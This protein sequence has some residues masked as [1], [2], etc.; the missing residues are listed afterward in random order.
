MP[1]SDYSISL[2]LSFFCVAVQAALFCVIALAVF[3][4]FI[5]LALEKEIIWPLMPR[6]GLGTVPLHSPIK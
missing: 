2:R 3:L 5:S 6:L 4:P 1:L